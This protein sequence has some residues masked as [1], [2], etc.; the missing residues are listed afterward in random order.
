[1]HANQEGDLHAYLV[2]PASHSG[3]IQLIRRSSGEYSRLAFYI[4][5]PGSRGS[6]FIG[7]TNGVMAV[8]I[9]I[10]IKK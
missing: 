6:R 8:R 10:R 3:F 4:P 5:P 2:W 1:M 7:G 9:N